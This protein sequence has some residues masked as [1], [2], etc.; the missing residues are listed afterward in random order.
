[1]QKVNI[2]IQAY[3]KIRYNDRNYYHKC[4]KKYAEN[5]QGK[6]ILEI[7]SGECTVERFFPNNNF[8]K[9]EIDL[10][11][12]FKIVDIEN[13]KEKNKWDIIIFGN[14]IEHIFYVQKAIDNMY[15]SLKPGGILL[16]H[17]IFDYPIHFEPH[18][19]WRVTEFGLR[20]LL[21]R[22][23]ELKIDSHGPKKKPFSYFITVKKPISY[24][25]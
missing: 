12:G 19:Y 6:D 2:F 5:I 3:R 18:D 7:G 14:I 22:F 9:S 16:I 8:V 20:K 10:K 21:E 24:K 13:Y 15:D 25:K 17:S 23:T 4:I 1:M 11:Y